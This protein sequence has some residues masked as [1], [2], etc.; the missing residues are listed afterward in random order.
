MKPVH[1][2]CQVVCSIVH[3]FDLSAQLQR[4]F[5]WFLLQKVKLMVTDP[6]LYVLQNY[7]TDFHIVYGKHLVFRPLKRIL[8]PIFLNFLLTVVPCIFP[9]IDI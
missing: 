9:L 7:G 4:S 6:S 8:K 3:L 1:H 2:I 5:Y